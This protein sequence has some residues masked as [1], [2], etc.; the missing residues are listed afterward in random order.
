MSADVDAILDNFSEMQAA[1]QSHEGRW[2]DVADYFMPNKNL[3]VEAKPTEIV[4]RRVTSSIGPRVLARGSALLVA[5]LLDPSRPFISPNVEGGFVQAGRSLNLKA[6]SH[7]YLDTLQW[8]M[9]DKMMR[10]KSNYWTSTTQ[11]AVELYGFGTCI[12]WTGRKKGFGPKYQYRPLRACWI[13]E[14]E[15]GDVDTLYFRYT[16]PLF[17]A[18]KKFPKLLENTE[19]KARFDDPQRR[20][21]HIVLLHCVEPRDGGVAGAVATNKPFTSVTIA[22]EQKI[23]AEESGYDS[24]PYSVARINV[25]EGSPYGTG[26]AWFALP[27]VKVINALQQGVE[28]SVALRLNPPLLMPKRMFG[29]PLDRRPGARN[30]Y[31]Q[32]GLGFQSAREAVQKLDV[33]GDPVIGV[34]YVKSLVTEVEEIFFVDW[35][36]LN[37]GVQK[38]AEEIRDRRDLRVRAMTALVPAVDRDLIG[39]DADRTLEV[40][41]EE[42]MVPPPPAELSDAMVEWDYKGP[43]AIMAQRG[44]FEA[45]DRIFDLAL[46]G[47]GLDEGGAK[48]V[49]VEECLRA[50]AEAVGI[51]VGALL[52]RTEMDDL[53][54]REAEGVQ[55]MNAADLAQRG[56]T[57]LRDA[58]QGVASL[59]AANAD[60]ADVEGLAAL[61]AN[62]AQAA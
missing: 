53:L 50:A 32:S 58:G 26:L 19:I 7:D 4:R 1:R 14:N 31:D 35:M 24:F 61:A 42:G 15:D 43:L 47:K 20:R 52:S 59:T 22:P 57:T 54:A 33:S 17:K 12:R 10:P 36:S 29:K 18:A 45:I 6:D 39:K 46:K 27:N 38:T 60:G 23:V 13:S 25:E 37:D 30:V 3:S 44:Q 49:A 51:P 48:V 16:L 41:T 62:A 8:Q 55:A 11:C 56:A 21:E 28:L 34:E 5:Y 40:M 2:R 9:F